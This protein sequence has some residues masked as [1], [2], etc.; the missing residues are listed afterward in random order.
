MM[1]CQLS[2]VLMMNTLNIASAK[3]SKLNLLF[4]HVPPSSTHRSFPNDGVSLSS[5]P[6]AIVVPSGSHAQYHIFPL[7]SSM[8]MML[9][10]VP[11]PT[12]NK[13]T[14]VIAGKL[15]MTALITSFK[16]GSLWMLLSGLSARKRRRDFN[17]PPPP[18]TSVNSE[19]KTTKTSRMLKEDLRYAPELPYSP[20]AY[21]FAAISAVKSIVNNTS[22]MKN[23]SNVSVPSRGNVC[24]SAASMQLLTPMAR[25]IR[26]SK[27]GCVTTRSTN[28]LK[29]PPS[30]PKNP[31]PPAHPRAS[32]RFRRRRST[33]S[34]QSGANA[35]NF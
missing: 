2:P 11:K 9:R 17:A 4:R 32:S 12:P 18:R 7:K 19:E 29:C 14:C 23:A 26:T 35:S 27:S 15:A 34:T 25:R 30:N 20:N 3:L 31:S 21:T 16:E 6:R 10:T 5:A 28:S 22:T 1:S 33:S 8:P 24:V 13:H